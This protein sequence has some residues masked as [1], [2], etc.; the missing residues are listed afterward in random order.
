MDA[1]VRIALTGAMTISA[2]EARRTAI[3]QMRLIDKLR[4]RAGTVRPVMASQVSS[5]TSLPS[6]TSFSPSRTAHGAWRKIT[7]H[8]SRT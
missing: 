8:D 6:R 5:S 1:Y 7:R 4:R 3:A 2:K